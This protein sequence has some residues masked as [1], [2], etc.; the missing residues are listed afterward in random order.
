MYVHG[1]AGVSNDK[2]SVRRYYNGIFCYV[3]FSV[4]RAKCNALCRATAKQKNLLYQYFIQGEESGKKL[5][6]DQVHRRL[7]KDLSPNEYVTSQQIR[8]LFSN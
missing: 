8:S 1:K 2:Y 3:Q 6:P 5:S 7:K 4:V